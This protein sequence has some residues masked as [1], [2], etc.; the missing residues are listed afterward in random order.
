MLTLFLSILTVIIGPD[1]SRL[2]KI[3]CG[4]GR[5]A[6]KEEAG[7]LQ[8]PK[9]LLNPRA[10]EVFT[11]TGSFPAPTIAIGKVSLELPAE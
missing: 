9:V 3:G 1:G 5:L 2:S 11:Q 6:I 10:M 4:Q 8:K 7:V